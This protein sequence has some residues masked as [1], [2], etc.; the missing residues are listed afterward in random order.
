MELLLKDN[1]IIFDEAEHKYYILDDDTMQVKSL[2]G[3]T[4]TIIR[5]LFPK[6]YEN[7]PERVL[8]LAAE[9][10]SKIHKAIEKGSYDDDDGQKALND[11]NR[12]MANA[13]LSCIEHEYLVTDNSFASAIDLVLKDSKNNIYLADIK[14]TSKI[15]TE[16]VS[17]QLSIYR[18][19]MKICNPELDVT[20]GYVLWL[21]KP[22]YGKPEL[23]EI[24]LVDIDKIK[25]MMSA[26]TEQTSPDEFIKLF[27]N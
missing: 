24:P 13:G 6:T 1:G 11:Y 18:Y 15:H 7:I 25:P 3:I 27:N 2:P 16:S 4:S 14:T 10:G 17:A 22:R 5:W 12:L 20:S 23:R 8:Q 9:Y 21:P 19:F 26:Y